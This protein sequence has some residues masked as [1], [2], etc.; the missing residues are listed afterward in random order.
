MTD[1]T[2][3]EIIDDALRAI[4]SER[5]VS[6]EQIRELVASG[7]LFTIGYGCTKHG[8][9]VKP[10]DMSIWNPKNWPTGRVEVRMNMEDIEP[11]RMVDVLSEIS[12][13]AVTFV[14]AGDGYR[15]DLK[16][17]ALEHT[18]AGSWRAAFLQKYRRLFNGPDP[19]GSQR[20]FEKLDR[21]SGNE[22]LKVPGY[23]EIAP[24]DYNEAQ[25]V[26]AEALRRRSVTLGDLIAN[27]NALTTATGIA[28]AVDVDPKTRPHEPPLPEIFIKRG[29]RVLWDGALICEAKVDILNTDVCSVDAF[30]WFVTKPS[31]GEPMANVRGFRDVD[32]KAEVFVEGEWRRAKPIFDPI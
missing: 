31:I 28:S 7:E 22:L 14:I 4:S 27:S 6:D 11:P 25:T 30:R 10:G 24:E 15:V 9:D 19:H 2:L 1:K 12:Q 29:E 32:G 26:L 13:D 3:N 20:Y 21:R 8:E 18:E 17:S 5:L 16:V 23:R